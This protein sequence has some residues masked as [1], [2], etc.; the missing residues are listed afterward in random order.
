MNGLLLLLIAF[1]SSNSE[2]IVN[3][4]ESNFDTYKNSGKALFVTFYA[5]C[6]ICN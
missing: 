2:G 1:A 4:D 5:V 3:L 6:L